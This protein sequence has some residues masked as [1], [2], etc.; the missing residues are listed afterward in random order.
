[1]SQERPLASA[2]R[3]PSAFLRPAL[4]EPRVCQKGFADDKGVCQYISAGVNSPCFQNGAFGSCSADNSCVAYEPCPRQTCKQQ[5][6]SSQ[7]GKCAYEPA[8]EKG[9]CLLT[10]A[11]VKGTCVDGQCQAVACE[12]K[13]CQTSYFDDLFQCRYLHVA[14][15][16]CIDNSGTNGFCTSNGRCATTCAEWGVTLAPCTQG[17]V[18]TAGCSVESAPVGSA[19]GGGLVGA[20]DIEHTCQECTPV[21][22]KTAVDFVFGLCK[23]Q[24]TAWDEGVPCVVGAERGTCVAGTCVSQSTCSAPTCQHAS[25]SSAEPTVCIYSNITASEGVVC[26]DANQVLEDASCFGQ[27]NIGACTIN[28]Q[29]VK[30]GL[31]TA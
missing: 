7:P 9:E 25:P 15:G 27:R 11:G 6:A 20:C 26:T 14:S 8:N 29:R 10:V 5:T 23:Y 19:C 1:M 12:A 18:T 4:S 24:A 13:P 3:T 16:A 2:A 28:K 30:A 22:C 21:Q 31:D 17:T